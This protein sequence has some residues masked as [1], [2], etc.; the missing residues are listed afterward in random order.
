MEIDAA[1]DQYELFRD[2]KD[3][4]DRIY[5]KSASLSGISEQP[6][7]HSLFARRRAR[8]PGEPA[9]PVGNS[10]CCGLKE[11]DN[12]AEPRIDHCTHKRHEAAALIRPWPS[13]LL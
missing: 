10:S 9:A 2:R 8:K 3:A 6:V 4:M 1:I 13:N 7:F 5:W 12:L 11:W